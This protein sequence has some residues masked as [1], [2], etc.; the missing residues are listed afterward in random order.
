MRNLIIILGLF[1]SLSVQATSVENLQI[2]ADKAVKKYQLPGLV[3]G[4][5]QDTILTNVAAGLRAKGHPEKVT[6][7]DQF[8]IGSCFKAITSTLVAIYVQRGLI[9]WDT[10]I[11]DVFLADIPEMNPLLKDVTIEELLAHRSG[12]NDEAL[13]KSISIDLLKTLGASPRSDRQAL[14]ATVLSYKKTYTR[15]DFHYSNV[16]YTI[17]G[18]MLEKL[19]NK[20]FE[21]LI[22]ENIFI[23]LAMDSAIFGAPESD[24]PDVIS[25]PMKHTPSGKPLKADMPKQRIKINKILSPA[26]GY[27]SMN[28]AD[29]NKFIEANF[30]G[31][32]KDG[33]KF[34]TDETINKI[35]S[36]V[37]S[38]AINNTGTS[39]GFG[40]IIVTVGNT[41]IF[42]H[43]GSDGYWT[44]MVT[45]KPDTKYTLLIMTNQANKKV[46]KAFSLILKETGL[47]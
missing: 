9:D 29:W 4:E 2:L 30:N 28:M 32:D 3:L 25:V 46:D 10:T 7:N 21:D 6:V 11:G 19:S 43:T 37:G 38:K 15:G 36:A 5:T 23:P 33:N 16:G 40:W 31:L 44:S 8:H 41:Q 14:L 42:T 27:T 35:H 18:A 20:A 24:D 17:A 34:L 47:L 13:N 45:R 26:G 22:T 39:Y 12:I 1:S